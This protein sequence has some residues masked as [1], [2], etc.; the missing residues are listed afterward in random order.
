ML[1][2]SCENILYTKTKLGIEAER[3]WKFISNK[4]NQKFQ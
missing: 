1:K 4:G 3:T 2:L